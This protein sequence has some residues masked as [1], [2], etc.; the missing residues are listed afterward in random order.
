MSEPYVV[1]EGIYFPE[2]L[3]WS[4]ATQSLLVTSVQQ[5]AVFQV[6]PAQGR[7]EQLADLGGGANNV[8]LA[9]DGGALVCQNGGLDAHPGIARSFPDVG[10]WPRI[11]PAQPGLV[12]VAPDGQWRYVLAD[13]LDTPNDI[14]VGADGTVYFTD[15]GNPF[16]GRPRDPRVLAW[17]ASGDVTT[18]A[19]GFD[20]CNGIDI[21]AD[22]TLIVT[23]HGG[24]LRVTPGGDKE[25]L[26]RGVGEPAPDGVTLDSQGNIY[27]AAS[28]RSGV[29][30]LDRSGTPLE[31]LAVP[32]DGSTSN[33]CFGGPDYRWLFATD[34]RRGQVVCF[35]DRPV[36]G[37]P[38]AVWQPAGPAAA[39]TSRARLRP[40]Y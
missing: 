31:F 18:V 17:S 33:C 15:P 14:V 21:D 16:L 10:P 4:A 39:E 38:P 13:R 6:W 7:Q 19:A 1:A 12:H 26:A 29:Q 3:A 25:W 27:V 9:A 40:S 22:G 11:R 30:V 37:R 24:V 35:P 8:A 34:T 20:Y 23:D 32:G 2:G 5:G 28:R 36:P